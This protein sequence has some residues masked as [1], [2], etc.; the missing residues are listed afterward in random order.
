MNNIKDCDIFSLHA[1]APD[2]TIRSLDHMTLAF[3]VPK[4]KNSVSTKQKGALFTPSDKTPVLDLFMKGFFGNVKRAKKAYSY[5]GLKPDEK[6]LFRPEIR[7]SLGVI[8]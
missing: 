8:P 5:F 4:S 7:Y 3:R 2:G 6:L 1:E